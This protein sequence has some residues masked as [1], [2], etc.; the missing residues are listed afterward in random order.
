MSAKVASLLIDVAADIASLKKDFDTASKTVSGFGDKIKAVGQGIAAAFS[1]H[2]IIAFGDRIQ[3]NIDAMADMA[4]NLKIPVEDFQTLQNAAYLAGQNIEATG[5]AIGK[6]NVFVGKATEGNKEAIETLN[7]LGVKINN[8]DGSS[9]S[10]TQRL[11]EIAEAITSITDPARRSAAEVAVFGKSGQQVSAILEQWKRPLADVNKE[12]Q[13]MGL[14]HSPEVIKSMAEMA[15]Q[16]DKGAKKLEVLFAP[17]YAAVK[18]ALFSAVAAGFTSIA[19]AINAISVGN[20]DAL[21]KSLTA[22]AL[23]STI[24]GIPA[25]VMMMQSIG[26]PIDVATSQ[27]R[28]AE[29]QLADYEAALESAKRGGAAFG[30]EVIRYAN[31]VAVAQL[32]VTDLRNALAKLTT[33]PTTATATRTDG[34]NPAIKATAGADKFA[35]AMKRIEDETKAAQAGI[36]EFNKSA[37]NMP[38]KQ[39]ER[40]AKLQVDIGKSISSFSKGLTPDQIKTITPLVETLEKLKFELAELG[41][42]QQVADQTNQQYGDGTKELTDKIYYLDEALKKNLITQEEYALAVADASQKQKLQAAAAQKSGDD[43][44]AMGAGMEFAARNITERYNEFN[45]GANLVT[46]G[47]EMMT[48]ALTEFIQKGELDFPKFAASF[49]A[50]I[51]SMIIKYLAA[52]AIGLLLDFSTGGGGKA[53]GSGTIA[54]APGRAAG[55]P[56]SAGSA[57]TVG[58]RGPETFVPSVNGTIVPNGANDDSGTVVVNLDMRKADGAR[59]PEAAL[60]FG[61]RVKAA[62]VSVIASERRPGGTLYTNTTGLTA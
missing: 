36:D 20:L 15:D 56:V 55:G 62:V 42:V 31:D 46:S 58:E 37:G 3:A 41:R 28:A 29:K 6:F 35:E 22:L 23:A 54:S 52:K 7:E 8:L 30:G 13:D 24:V 19:N 4:E 9:K 27:L 10:T 16:A 26:D 61:R 14:V 40:L 44:K 18:G 5:G 39:A 57:Y 45:T 38:T 33:K 51:Q 48:D 25:A 21:V 1:A 59:N 2:E 43:L 34:T 53:P 12:L 32:K 47:F 60:E 49:A 17:L 50:M 11:Q